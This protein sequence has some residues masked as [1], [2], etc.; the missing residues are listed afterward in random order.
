MMTK[1]RCAQARGQMETRV[2][3]QL[4]GSERGFVCPRKQQPGRQCRGGVVACKWAG[5][6]G[7]A[8]TEQN[9]T[10]KTMAGFA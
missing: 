10:H 7:A 1:S 2:Q 8:G 4:S 9:P 5:R 6:A 3:Q